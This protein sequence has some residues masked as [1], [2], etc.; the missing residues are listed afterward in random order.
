[1]HKTPAVGAPTLAEV[2]EIAERN[3]IRLSEEELREYQEFMSE[4]V[5]AM[6]RIDRLP[7]PT[8]PVKY[9]RVPGYRPPPEENRHN[10]W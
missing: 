2:R 6:T 5:K 4:G 7:E 3:N 9:P 1:M 10:A 8:L